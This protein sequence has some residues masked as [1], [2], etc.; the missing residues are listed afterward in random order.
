[1][2]IKHIVGS[3]L[4][5]GVCVAMA[6]MASGDPGAG[7]PAHPGGTRGVPPHPAPAVGNLPSLDLVTLRSVSVSCA[8][9]DVAQQKF[10]DTN[11]S[12]TTTR[13]SCFPY[14]CDSAAKTCAMTCSVDAHCSKG[15]KCAAGK[16]ELAP[17]VPTCSADRATS[18][19]PTGA[20]SRCLP[21][22]C[23]RGTGACSKVCGTTDDCAP[24]FVCD[25]TGSRS[26]N[27][28]GG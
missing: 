8:S 13:D 5:A 17:Q 20:T 27:R 24:G 28:V 1:M 22:A 16:C 10:C 21:F 25:S 6:G 23:D 14:K 9:E 2:K 15:A 12:C 18:I 26:C 3:L 19:H 4:I 7:V 11:N